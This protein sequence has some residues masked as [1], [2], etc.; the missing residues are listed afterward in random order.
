M[1]LK[2]TVQK[3]VLSNHILKSLQKQMFFKKGDLRNFLIFT[4]KHLCW[5]GILIKVSGC[6]NCNFIYKFNT[7]F[8]LRIFQ[9]FYEQLF[10]M[11]PPLAA[12]TDLVFLIK[13]IMWDGFYYKG[14]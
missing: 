10:Y 3:K 13:S 14:L 4:R 7:G 11:T 12:F 2:V 5:S 8:F 1:L 9:N 6:T